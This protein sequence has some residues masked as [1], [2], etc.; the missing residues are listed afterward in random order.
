MPDTLRFYLDEDAMR[1]SIVRALRARH[2][3]VITAFEA[4]LMGQLDEVH[5]AHAAAQ[6]RVLVT[7]NRGDFAKLHKAYLATSRHHAGI[8]LSDQLGTGIIVRRLLKLLA[9]RSAEDM[10]DWLEYLSSWR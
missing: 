1:T 8:V 5:L 2:V 10:H 4:D 6:G 7:F 9:S 3:D